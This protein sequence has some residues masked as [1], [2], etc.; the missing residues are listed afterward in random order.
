MQQA[1]ERS[2]VVS[3]VA[4][5][6]HPRTMYVAPLDRKSEIFWWEFESEVKQRL[7]LEISMRRMFAVAPT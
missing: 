6:Q 4:S 7:A 1:R 2:R 3:A 5:P